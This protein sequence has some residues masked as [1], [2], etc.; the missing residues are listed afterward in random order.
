MK[1]TKG[2]YWAAATVAV[3][4]LSGVGQLAAQN[5]AA[6]SK[7]DLQTMKRSASTPEEYRALASYYRGQQQLYLAKAEEESRELARVP[8]STAGASKHPSEADT[9]RSGRDYYLS[10]ASAMSAHANK[11]EARLQ[12]SP[13]ETEA[14]A[15]TA[16]PSLSQS[17]R[18][19][20]VS[21]LEQTA[22]RLEKE[23]QELRQ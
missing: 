21:K 12:P 20:L 13:G 14:A 2:S 23:A 16:A 8:A 7:E 4:I 17:E 3:C 6:I 10:K 1:L 11:Y 9:L 5:Q 19:L 22:K 15:A 18:M